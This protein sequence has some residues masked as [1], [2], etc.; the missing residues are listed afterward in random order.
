MRRAGRLCTESRAARRIEWP[1]RGTDSC[2]ASDR[3]GSD[4]GLTLKRSTLDRTAS[5]A[6]QLARLSVVL[7]EK[8]LEVMGDDVTQEQ[9]FAELE[10][11]RSSSTARLCLQ[12]VVG[13]GR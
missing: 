12:F 11:I 1:L 8:L 2:V 10:L 5:A 7:N 4:S 3:S 9:G 6:G 13:D